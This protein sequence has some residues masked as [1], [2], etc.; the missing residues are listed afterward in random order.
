MFGLRKWLSCLMLFSLMAVIL[1]ACGGAETPADGTGAE[2]S[3]ATDGTGV[4][5]SPA[6]E[7]TGAE[8]TENRLEIFS[9][10]T[11]EGE[12]EGKE[13]LFEVYKEQHPDVKIVDATVTGG[14]GANAKTVLVT[15]M[16]GGQPPDSFQVHAGQELIGTWVVADRM[17]P[18]TF[19]FEE[20]GWRDVMPE[21]LLD[22]ITHEGEIYS[23]PVNIHR[24]NV[25][26]YNK[27]IFEENNLE[28]PTTLDEF[29]QVAEQLQAA[30]VTP[31]AI[32]A[33]DAFATPH[34]FES[35]LLATFGPED[36]GQLFQDP[37]MWEDPR[38]TQAIETLGRM[39]EY[40]NEDRASLTWQD[41][42]RRVFDG[43]AAMT[44]MGDWTEGFF[45]TLGGEPNVEF[46]WEPAPGTEGAFMWLSDSFGL[47]QGAP[48]RDNAVEWLRVAGSKEGQDAFNPKKGSIPARTDADKS[49]YDEYL[50]Y[51]I[52]AFASDTLAPS[53]VHGAAAP[54]AFMSTYNNAVNVFA[55]DQDAEA[56]QQALSDA[57]LDLEQ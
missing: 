22:Q 11:G 51:S 54:E 38:I 16:Q 4:E 46:G 23:V 13:A 21:L 56:F 52:D 15:R 50:Q 42:S 49:L 35:V 2:A 3:P 30:G 44:V 45:K 28:P 55:A 43:E 48:H 9:W 6:T 5:G 26:W 31:L 29:F 32:G 41:A 1:A 24:S 39:L 27:Q 53:I 33:K 34:L 18:I 19:I 8:G 12:A 57:A 36:Y 10:W 20:E 25:L 47:P 14:A 17:E 40:S 7:D 37:S